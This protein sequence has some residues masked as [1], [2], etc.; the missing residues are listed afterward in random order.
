MKAVMFLTVTD[1]AFGGLLVVHDVL[2][3]GLLTVVVDV[4][5][6]AAVV[7]VGDVVVVVDCVV[8]VV[9]VVDVEVAPGFSYLLSVDSWYPDQLV[10]SLW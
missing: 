9:V 7:V 1:V 10:G 5:V 4:V 3:S 6:V 8:V 2:T